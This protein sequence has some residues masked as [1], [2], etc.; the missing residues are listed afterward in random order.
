MWYGNDAQGKIK[1]NNSIRQTN[2]TIYGQLISHPP[3]Y[4]P[5]LNGVL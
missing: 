5:V 3:H 1:G 2:T 4:T